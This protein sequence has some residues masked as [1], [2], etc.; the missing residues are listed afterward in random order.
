MNSSNTMEKRSGELFGNVIAEIASSEGQSMLVP[1]SMGTDNIYRS[2]AM[3]ITYD[4]NQT[5]RPDF[6]EF[7]ITESATGTTSISI[8]LSGSK[9]ENATVDESESVGTAIIARSVEDIYEC[10]GTC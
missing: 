6:T 4:P 9:Q 1:L 10:A 8:T 2:N 7:Q 3:V 5:S